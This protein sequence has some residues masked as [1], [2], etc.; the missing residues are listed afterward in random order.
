MDTVQAA[1]YFPTVSFAAQWGSVARYAFDLA[2][3]DRSGWVIP[4]G[5]SGEPQCPHFA[6]QQEAWREGRLLMAPYTRAA[7]E[8]AAAEHLVLRPAR[9]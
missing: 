8:A 5:V 1:S 4:L 7:V 6:D 2:D 9:L 3:W